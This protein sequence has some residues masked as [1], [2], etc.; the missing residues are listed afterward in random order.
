MSV[1]QFVIAALRL[2]LSDETSFHCH[3]LDSSLEKAIAHSVDKA[4]SLKLDSFLKHQSL[5]TPTTLDTPLDTPTILD[6]PTTL[7]APLDT[8]EDHED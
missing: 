2:A 3:K 5:D 6:T 7:D 8:I 4:I 1:N